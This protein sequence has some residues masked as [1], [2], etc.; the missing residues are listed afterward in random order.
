M[1]KLCFIDVETG[2]TNPFK[3][4]L[5]QISGIIDVDGTTME[6]F[7]LY[8]KPF[9]EDVIDPKALEKN[10]ITMEEIYHTEKY[11]APQIV[12]RDLVKILSIYIDKFNKKDKFFLVGYNS[13]SFDMAV[14]R[15]FF[16][17]NGDNYFGSFFH[18]PSIDVM[19]LA[20]YLLMDIRPDMLNFQLGTVAR[21][22]G[23]GDEI[24]EQ[25]HDSHF[26]CVLTRE[27]YYKLIET[28]KKG[29]LK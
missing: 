13:H 22:L 6:S 24:D 8:A 4:P 12:Y 3:A 18:F 17:K 9:D 7:D 23:Y 14:L 27:M 15:S 29:N 2:G 25:L 11:Q 20:A 21:T 10:K 28:L 19:F 1:E 5:L 16:T 26:D